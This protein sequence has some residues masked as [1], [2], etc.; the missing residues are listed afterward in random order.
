[1]SF[2]T[3]A[4]L[5]PGLIGGS[6]ALALAERKLADKL[7]IY[8]RSRSSLA[9][10]ESAC[11]MA[12]LTTDPKEAVRDADIVVLC[13]PIEAM[14]AFVAPIAH[15]F[16][17]S[18]LV[19]D[20]GSVKGK[21]ERDLAPLLVNNAH[22]IG[23]HPMAGS[24]KSGFGAARADLFDGATVVITPTARTS[25]LA[26]KR[27]G[28]FWSALGGRVVSLDPE[29]HDTYVAQISHLPHLVAAALVNH[30]SA[31]ARELAGGGFRD[32][33]RVASGSPELWAEILAANAGAVGD[34]LDK[35]MWGLQTLRNA[36]GNA[37]SDETKSLLRSTLQAAHDARS[38]MTEANP[39]FKKRP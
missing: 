37:G 16:K 11:P 28:E 18:A 36:L 25:L 5:G 8:A 13:L 33:T 29:T 9:A 14:F 39:L 38:Q 34:H 19:T 35:L 32:T 10:I 12:G 3:V 30:S 4:I 24:E 6:L 1:M 2:G 26:E 21:V 15:L 17:S 31:E 22:W 23:S 27:A 7:V 20:V